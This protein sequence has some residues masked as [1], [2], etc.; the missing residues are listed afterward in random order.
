[1]LSHVYL[2]DQV[3]L[4]PS[5]INYGCSILYASGLAAAD[6]ESY[7]YSN[8]DKAVSQLHIDPLYQH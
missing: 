6:D 4:S 7:A 3:A 2:E 5:S 8:A 1:M